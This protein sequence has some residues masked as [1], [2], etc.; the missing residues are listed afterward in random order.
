MRY[1]NNRTAVMNVA[2]KMLIDELN[3][4]IPMGK[5]EQSIKDITEDLLKGMKQVEVI[6]MPE[7]PIVQ[8]I[9]GWEV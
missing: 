6:E 4:K 7:K 5:R 3:T 9:G 8:M 2:V 1:K